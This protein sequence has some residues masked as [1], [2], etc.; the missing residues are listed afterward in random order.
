MGDFGGAE[1]KVAESVGA[2][3]AM[4]NRLQQK[5]RRQ[6]MKNFTL[7]DSSETRATLVKLFNTEEIVHENNSL[8]Q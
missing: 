2:L 7:F 3:T 8:L 6:V 1:L 4:L 5:E